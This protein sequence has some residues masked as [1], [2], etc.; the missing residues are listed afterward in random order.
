MKTLLMTAV[1]GLL[2]VGLA[3]SQRQTV[4]V[5]GVAVE[6]TVS[7]QGADRTLLLLES[8]L[9]RIGALTPGGSAQ[10]PGAI[11]GCIGDTLSNGAFTVK[12]VSAEQDGNKYNFAWEL[13]NASS[14][15]IDPHNYFTYRN[16]EVFNAMANADGEI[17][18]ISYPSVGSSAVPPGGLQRVTGQAT[19]SGEIANLNRVIFRLSDSLVDLLVRGGTPVLDR[20]NMEFDLTCTKP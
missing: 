20:H 3:Q 9:Q 10:T 5:N 17:L 1:L 6:A 15:N 4:F 12:L 7:G 11:R 8:D 19:N 14:R 2:G 18:R 13:R 16:E